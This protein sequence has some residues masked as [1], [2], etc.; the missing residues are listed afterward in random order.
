MLVFYALVSGYIFRLSKWLYPKNSE[1]HH[2]EV[3]T[4]SD[5]IISVDSFMWKASY[6]RG[7]NML[8]GGVKEILLKKR[9]LVVPTNALI[10]QK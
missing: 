6:C 9:N 8:L 1:D 2:T 3:Y 4:N 5:K 10:M 7:F